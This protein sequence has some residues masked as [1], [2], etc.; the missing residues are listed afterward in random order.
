MVPVT[1]KNLLNKKPSIIIT[2]AENIRI[3]FIDD[4]LYFINVY[5]ENVISCFPIAEDIADRL[6]GSYT[7]EMQKPDGFTLEMIIPRIVERQLVFEFTHYTPPKER[8]QKKP[9]E[10]SGWAYDHT[11][12]LL[13]NRDGEMKEVYVGNY[14]LEGIVND[15]SN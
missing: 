3:D 12:R 2:Q 13:A 8:K 4:M 11:V 6:L 9:K 1:I 15:D 14:C 7:Y 5:T 10:T